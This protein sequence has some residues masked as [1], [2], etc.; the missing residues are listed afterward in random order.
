MDF[1]Y[2][3]ILMSDGQL[4][5]YPLEKLPRVE[6]ATTHHTAETQR[7]SFSESPFACAL[8]GELG[9]AVKAGTE[10][11]KSRE[12]L[13]AA[14][15]GVHFHLARYKLPEMAT[16]KAPIPDDPHVLTRHIKSLAYFLGADMVGVCRLPQ[17]AVYSSDA[18]GNPIKADYKYAV[19][20]L[21]VKKTDT[22]RASYGREWIDDPVSFQVYQ[23]C[24]LQCEAMADY[25]LR[26]GYPAFP[27]IVGTYPNLMTPLI[28]EAGLG[29][30]SR[31]GIAVNPFV[32]A[33]FKAAAVLTDLPLEV[34]KPIDFG[35]QEYCKTCKICAE[36]C[37][38]HA[39]S[40]RDK[41]VYNGYETYRQNR[42]LCHAGVM[43]NPVGNMC[44][45]CT[46]MCPW[47]RPDNRPEDFRDWNGD[48][49]FI[50]DSVNRQAKRLRDNNFVDP[51]EFTNKW[52]FPLEFKDGKLTDAPEFDYAAHEQRQRQLQERKEAGLQWSVAPD[53]L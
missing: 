41:E 53:Y 16:E 3:E 48:L 14:M 29:E 7:R 33:S 35:L 31:L 42:N 39:V 45:H 11:F 22:I 46:K 10:R 32:G 20:V 52:W 5:P 38:M 47:N 28:I 18:E 40:D 49:K 36:Q 19:V 6:T 27:S 12:P 17:S 21:N 24:G 2:R 37:P 23:Q 43:T 13:L 30:G 26:L 8:R 34:D 51:D 15:T 1:R 44:Q 9:P 4:G 25:I 50:Y